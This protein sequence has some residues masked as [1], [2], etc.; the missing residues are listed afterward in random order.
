MSDKG[1]TAGGPI[2]A[3]APTQATGVGPLNLFGLLSYGL[4]TMPIAMAGLAML[5][6]LP[7][8]YAVDMGLG[9]TAVGVAAVIGRLLDVFTDPLI[10]HLSDQ[11]RTRFGPRKPWMA[12]GIA[13][14]CI[15]IWFALS[16]PVGADILY[17]ALIGASYFLFLTL[18]DVPYSSVGLEL[19]SDTRERTR[20]ASV[21]AAFQVAGAI[22]A[23]FFPLI[24]AVPVA[25]ALPQMALTIIV[26]AI[27]GFALFITVIPVP[28]RNVVR[29][30]L[31]AMAALRII[32]AH[33][34]FRM[35][36]GAF[37]LV[38]TGNAFFSGLAV[39]YVTFV[40]GAEPLIGLMIGL[41]FL[42]TAAWLPLW[43]ILEGRTGKLAAWRTGIVAS[44]SGFALL[45]LC[46]PGDTIAIA[47]LFFLIG[48]TFG[49]DAVVPTSI[50]ADISYEQEVQENR[51]QSGLFVAIK[52]STS[53]VAF[54]VPLAVAF[55]LLDL[56]QFEERAGSD[57]VTNLV[58]MAFF[59]VIPILFKLAALGLL[60]RTRSHGLGS[61]SKVA[62]T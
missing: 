27:A 42:G 22:L 33:R 12:V 36:L 14:F 7:T 15:A 58:F 41:L 56:F 54:V 44:A 55:P 62:A 28:H 17:L 3:Q 2:A 39:L 26:L 38:Q 24:L 51:R 31:G 18:L 6:Y 60:S 45:A 10:G 47:A 23:G 57:P 46:G 1:G 4:L 49:A 61:L 29:P 37:A 32:G 25:Q 52:N 13:G 43:S 53:K 40:L 50:L 48:G 21:K 20:L 16:P 34:R 8:F 5:T 11:T 9:L 59:A 30:R 35:L 19:S